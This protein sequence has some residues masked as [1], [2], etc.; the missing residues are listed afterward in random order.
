MVEF[1]MYAMYL[2]AALLGGAALLLSLYRF[3]RGPSV[4]DRVVSFDIMNV[5]VLSYIV[6]ISLAEGRG[7]YID[8]AT[9]YALL[10]FLGVIVVARY[11][12]RGL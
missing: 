2:I 11:L 3:F 9:I 5:I 12:E 10:S 4:V 6:V 1:L 7:T 8:V